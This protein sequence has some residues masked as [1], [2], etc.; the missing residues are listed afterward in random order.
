[1]KPQENPEKLIA[2]LKLARNKLGEDLNKR[3]PQVFPQK[4]FSDMVEQRLEKGRKIRSLLL[5]LSAT[6]LYPEKKHAV[7]KDVCLDVCLAIEM[8]HAA[9]CL[10]DDILDGDDVRHGF[11]SSHAL[12]GTPLAVLQSHILC[13]EAL[14][15]VSKWPTITKRLIGTYQKL[16]VGE[17]YDILLPEPKSEW[18]R[19][20]YTERIYQKTSAMFEFALETA[21]IIAK[22]PDMRKKLKSLGCELGKLYQL[23][24]DYYDLKPTNLHKRHDPDHSWRITF[25]LPLACYLE[26]YGPANIEDE[27]KKGMLRF[28][29]WMDFLEK[30]WTPKV[31]KVAKKL[32]DD[33]QKEVCE[34]IGASGLN[35][36]AQVDYYTLVDLIMK[37]DFWYHSYDE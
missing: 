21:A 17:T 23:S 22:R 28:D 34:L 18:L 27:L 30:I 24:N 15:L 9:S 25:S 33:T 31:E 13:A 7:L 37:E 26:L 5:F 16:T 20:G 4:F 3:I 1:M 29:E 36:W 11:Q 32:M 14:K 8:I 12:L 2:S 35:F 10:V 19:E 6:S